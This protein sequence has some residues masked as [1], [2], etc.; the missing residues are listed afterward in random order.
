[1]KQ[2]LKDFDFLKMVADRN[3][4]MA[5]VVAQI[6]DDYASGKI[7]EQPWR[8]DRCHS[9]LDGWLYI[10]RRVWLDYS[11][12]M[13][14]EDGDKVRCVVQVGPD[15]T[16]K[17]VGLLERLSKRLG[18]GLDLSEL[19]LINTKVTSGGL[20]RLTRLFPNAKIKTYSRDEHERN[21]EL[22]FA[23]G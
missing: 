7:R 21:P 6:K 22:S 14:W 20:R 12:H 11:E 16:D 8:W 15:F 1:M 18:P 3:P 13:R 23:K 10:Y 9:W 2:R 5:E 19:R 17:T 4:D